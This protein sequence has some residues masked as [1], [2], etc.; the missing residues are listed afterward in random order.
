M[1]NPV[2]AGQGLNNYMLKVVL[3]DFG[4]DSS[5]N[6]KNHYVKIDLQVNVY[7]ASYFKRDI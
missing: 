5:T 1:M 7:E 3:Y 6:V 4:I 2:S